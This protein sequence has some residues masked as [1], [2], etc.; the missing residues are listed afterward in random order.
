MYLQPLEHVEALIT[1]ENATTDAGDMLIQVL[2]TYV[3][4]Y[5][6]WQNLM[7]QEANKNFDTPPH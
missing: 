6:L 2:W 4:L 7:F 1:S 3:M 5:V